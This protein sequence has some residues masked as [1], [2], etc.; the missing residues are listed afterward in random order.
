[1]IQQV[2]SRGDSP[3]H[4][5]DVRGGLGFVACPFGPRAR[6]TTLRNRRHFREPAEAH[7]RRIW[8]SIFRIS[9]DATANF[10]D[11]LRENKAETARSRFLIR[12]HGRNQPS[13]GNVRPRG[14]RADARDQTRKASGIPRRKQSVCHAELRSCNHPPADRFAVEVLTVARHAF[15]RVRERMAEVQDFTQ[16]GFALIAGNHPR[17]LRSRTAQ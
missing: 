2:V 17:L 6:K 7:S 12:L 14:Q 15:E 8:S 4:F 9:L 13:G 16:S 1:M 5:P 10:S 11:P 3:K